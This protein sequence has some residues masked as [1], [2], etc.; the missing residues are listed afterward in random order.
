MNLYEKVKNMSVEQLAAWHL[1]CDECNYCEYCDENGCCRACD[2]E[3][4]MAESCK[5]AVVKML[6]SEV[7]E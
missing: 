6:E 1:T 3:V 4:S 5:K 7:D 2:S